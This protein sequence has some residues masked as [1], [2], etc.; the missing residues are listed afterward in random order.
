[1][2]V[3]LPADS[4]RLVRPVRPVRRI[5][6]T[7][8]YSLFTLLLACLLPTAT[9]ADTVVHSKHNL[10]VSGPGTIKASAETD[11][12]L[13]C[14]TVHKTTGQIPLWSH[15]MSSV[16]N[17]V[18]YSS[19]T[20]KAT[21]GQPDGSSRLCLSCHD[22]TVALGMVSSRTTTIQ[23][24]SGVTTLPSGP[25]NLG[26]D[27][28]GDHPISFVYDPN[29]AT[30]DP[31]VQDPS[32]IDKRL[33]LD[34]LQKMQCVTCHDPH[35]DQYGS[36]LVM[37]NT[38]SALCLACHIQP[39]W[40]GSAHALATTTPTAAASAA[41]AT[42]T[43]SLPLG[44]SRSTLHAPRSTTPSGCEICHTSHKAGSKARLLIQAREEQNCFVCHNG[45]AIAKDLTAE[46][47]KVSAHPVL[48][49]STTH[50][51]AENPLNSARHTACS[52]CHNSHA[53]KPDPGHETITQPV[54]R[55]AHPIAGVK[56]VNSSGAVINPATREYE[57]CFRCHADSL[58]R[59]PSL[60]TRQFVETNKRLQF[61]ISN[62]SFHPVLTP[63]RNANVPSLIAPWTTSSLVSCTDCHNN[64]QGPKAGGSG[65]N[66]PHG[67]SF[68]P[69]LERRLLL[70][71]FQRESPANYAL[72]YKCHDRSSILRDQSF[73]AMN[74]LG[75]DR[76]HR[77]HIEDAKAACTTCHDSHGVADQ[78]RLINFN[79]DY[80][81]P[82]S[83]G[84]LEFISTGRFSGSCT[85]TCHDKPHLRATYPFLSKSARS[86]LSG[87]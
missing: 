84:R 63:G 80:V 86:P 87:R 51:L 81:T 64:D 45:K 13:F 76:G 56:G 3:T 73:R 16:T 25:S 61:K 49:T 55:G 40:T 6:F 75:Q 47:R 78:Q 17:Y 60:I 30:A 59:A 9:S 42:T 50:S 44:P 71:D 23:M 70:A 32:A 11:V 83:N 8:H 77:F 28:S 46:F 65:A 37:D 68:P 41:S 66:G 5:L 33:K 31:G 20:L 27:L 35:D 53:A 21:V 18:V 72:C 2:R 4:K 48:Q 26:T 24:Q 1:M 52:D 82:S 67:S 12:C 14:H 57:L 39:G 85:L 34:S 54:R 74:Q 43:R 19:P 29:L 15:A 79:R 7:A 69:L 38:G 36:F 22:G 10:S 58:N 62:Q